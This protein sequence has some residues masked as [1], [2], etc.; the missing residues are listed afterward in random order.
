LICFL[1]NPE[2]A[3]KF[4]KALK[5]EGIA[6][7][8]MHDKSVPDWHIYNHWEMILKKW[9]ATGEGCPYTCDYYLR[10][11]G[12]VEYRADMNPKTLHYLNRSI[13]IDIPPQM[14][15]EDCEMIADGIIKVAG[16]YL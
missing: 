15:S 3:G 8:S 7:S 12:K 9:T 4:A 11:G 5:E 13:H 2:L 10:N 16:A 6:V 14:S 1:E